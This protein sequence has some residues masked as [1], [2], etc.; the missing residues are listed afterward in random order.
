MVLL[1]TQEPQVILAMLEDQVVPAEL[2]QL[3]GLL[4]QVTQVQQGLMVTLGRQGLEQQVVMLVALLQQT[5]LVKTD[6]AETL[7]IQALQVIQVQQD[8]LD[9]LAPQEEIRYLS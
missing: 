1:E 8:P 9:L 7:V 3:I 4:Q 6:Q 5:G 2:L